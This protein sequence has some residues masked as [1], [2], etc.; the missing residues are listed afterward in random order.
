MFSKINI[1]TII[2][3]SALTAYLFKN[4]TIFF[5]RLTD[6]GFTYNLIQFIALYL[7]LFF[8]V[9]FASTVENKFIKYTYLLLFFISSLFYDIFYRV[10]N[11][12]LFYETFFTLINEMSFLGD[13]LFQ[14]LKEVLYSAFCSILLFLGF[15]IAS[16]HSIKNRVV[17]FYPASL[18][19]LLSFILYANGG[20]G[21]RALPSMY[22]PLSYYNLYL[23]DI[24]QNK[25]QKRNDVDINLTNKHD[26][27]DI[28]LIIDESV[29]PY[30]LNVNNIDEN[31]INLINT[32]N[33]KI[34]IFN[35][36][37]AVSATNCSYGS[38]LYLRY[39]GT[40]GNY[41]DTIDT[42]PSIWK[43]AKMAGYKTIYI[44]SQR[45][46]NELQ[47][48]M[49]DI[50]LNL[51]DKFIQFNET[52]IVFRDIQAAYELV[53]FI[54]NDTAEFIILNKIGAHFP[55]NDKYPDEYLKYSP[56]LKRGVSASISDTG[57]RDGFDGEQNDWLMY[58]NSYRNT[59]LWNVGEFFKIIIKNSLLNKCIIIYTS[60]HGQ[61][62]HERGNPGKNTHCSYNPNIEEGVVPLVIISGVDVYNEKLADKL[63]YN[64]N[65]SGHYNIF[66]TILR[67]MQYDQ[68]Q[69]EVYYGKSLF[70]ITNDDMTFNTR[71]N[72]RFGTRPSWKKIIIDP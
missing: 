29:S 40:R 23:Y 30:Y 66:P 11:D 27:N 55:V 35:Y 49:T 50:E 14:N 51:I 37:Y 72:A 19:F 3:Y 52:E 69:V 47:N 71:F 26:K 36:N 7:M 34:K 59:L 20:N 24:F 31:K 9:I 16:K 39:G 2:K 12:F 15:I 43:Y 41:K 68:N 4:P 63:K 5:E 33:S 42:M 6:L 18:I 70:D 58:R 17:C 8:G 13:A 48:G 32:N 38:N 60:D 56:V 25:L 57:S 61:D 53:K 65:S 64:I 45:T 22:L 54:N 62:L 1:L 46:N 28:V 67:L 21:G 10:T 44:D